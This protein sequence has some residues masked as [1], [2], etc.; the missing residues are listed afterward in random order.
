MFCIKC[1]QQL[2][3]DA[4]FCF[5]CGAATVQQNGVANSAQPFDDYVAA[6]AESFAAAGQHVTES[7]VPSQEYK[8]RYTETMELFLTDNLYKVKRKDNI[9]GEVVYSLFWNDGSNR[10]SEWFD[11][12]TY[13]DYGVYVVEKDEKK[14]LMEEDTFHTYMYGRHLTKIRD[15][16]YW[17]YRNEHWVLVNIKNHAIEELYSYDKMHI[18]FNGMHIIGDDATKEKLGVPVAI[19]VSKNDKSWFWDFDD[20]TNQAINP[21]SC[22]FDDIKVCVESNVFIVRCGNKYGCVFQEG[23]TLYYPIN[24]VLDAMPSAVPGG[25]KAEVKYNG[26]KFFMDKEGLLWTRRWRGMGRMGTIGIRLLLNFSI[27]GLFIFCSDSVVDFF[28]NSSLNPALLAISC[29]VIA[30][31]ILWIWIRI[32]VTKICDYLGKDHYT[33]TDIDL[34]KVEE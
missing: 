6:K 30:V 7:H 12:I 21:L 19:V 23:N 11:A 10:Q 20:A 33:K 13:K 24:C 32:I 26:K 5:K 16:L 1:G 8:P 2:P 34:R 31:M 3:D 17:G 15:G 28:N 14:G 25:G 22:E 29:V 18:I 27:I 9:T 4:R